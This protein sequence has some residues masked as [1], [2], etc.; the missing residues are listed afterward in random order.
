MT[1]TTCALSS[2]GAN[3]AFGSMDGTIALVRLSTN[4]VLWSQKF[5]KQIGAVALGGNCAHIGIGFFVGRVI[6]LQVCAIMAVTHK[7][8]EARCRMGEECREVYL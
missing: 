5:G 8:R 7:A 4:E 3:I 6:W 1:V 2:D